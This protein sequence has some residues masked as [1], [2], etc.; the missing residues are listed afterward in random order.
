[1]VVDLG[2]AA[3]A[4]CT[5]LKKHNFLYEL[6]ILPL[7]ADSRRQILFSPLRM[8][9]AQPEVNE[10]VGLFNLTRKRGV[11]LEARC[12]NTGHLSS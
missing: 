10:Q 2:G 8:T 11:F 7:R 6:S 5:I 1:M 12:G 9:M 3:A 4:A